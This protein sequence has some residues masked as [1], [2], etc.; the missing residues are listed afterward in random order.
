MAF[1]EW[2]TTHPERD[3]FR[4]GNM[5]SSNGR[6]TAIDQRISI[7]GIRIHRPSESV[8]YQTVSL[9]VVVR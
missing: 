5:R 1:S 2:P 3:R 8:R 6:R 7:F 9:G 4:D